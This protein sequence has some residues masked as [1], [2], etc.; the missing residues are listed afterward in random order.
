MF[1]VSLCAVLAAPGGG[2]GRQ[3]AG[4]VTDKQPRRCTGTGRGAPFHCRVL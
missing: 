2:R 3:R 1:A 4:R